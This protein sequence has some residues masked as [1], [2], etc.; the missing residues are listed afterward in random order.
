MVAIVP[1]VEKENMTTKV[2][3]VQAAGN[4]RRTAG[5]TVL[6][7]LIPD[8]SNDI[9]VA[10]VVDVDL[11]GKDTKSGNG[12]SQKLFRISNSSVEDDGL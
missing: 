3:Q 7:G 11:G 6:P 4:L 12:L 9:P 5:T 2:I 8:V 10:K 1:A